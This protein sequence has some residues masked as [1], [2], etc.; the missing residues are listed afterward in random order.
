MVARWKLFR[1][2][3]LTKIIYYIHCVVW[4]PVKFNGFRWIRRVQ[5]DVCSF[6]R[7]CPQTWLDERRKVW[8]ILKRLLVM[9]HGHAVDWPCGC[10]TCTLSYSGQWR[11]WY[12]S[13]QRSQFYI[14]GG[15]EF[16]ISS[17][18][19]SKSSLSCKESRNAHAIF[20]RCDHL[21]NCSVEELN[22]ML[23]SIKLYAMNLQEGRRGK[24]SV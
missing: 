21:Y 15:H 2:Y 22:I 4:G 7:S 11:V 24:F 23:G 14:P 13:W 12:T 10:K 17:T 8:H 3:C 16:I 20:L 1:R 6:G 18:L 19:F 5:V 9:G